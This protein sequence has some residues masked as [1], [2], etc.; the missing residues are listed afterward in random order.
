MI[1]EKIADT[2][3]Y[4]EPHPRDLPWM[5]RP[6]DFTGLHMMGFEVND[7]DGLVYYDHTGTSYGLLFINDNGRVEVEWLSSE[8][9]QDEVFGPPLPSRIDFSAVQ[10]A[11][12]KSTSGAP[13]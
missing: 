10:A 8:E 12:S 13:S 3:H 5:R 2:F 11:F 7:L 6:D 1:I 9:P 4:V